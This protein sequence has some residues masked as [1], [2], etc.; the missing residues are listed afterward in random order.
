MFA[1]AAGALACG[2]GGPTGTPPA[3]TVVASVAVTSPATSVAVGATVQLAATAR[4]AAGAAIS[5]KTFTWTTSDAAV[6]TI[7]GTGVLSGVAL[8]QVVVTVSESGSGKSATVTM[9]VTPP[10]VASV[11][12]TPATATVG[13]GQ[14]QQL[15]ATLKDARGE[16]LSGRTIT[17]SS[18]NAA[19]A[20]VSGDG[21]VTGVAAGG[22]V[23]ITA[24]SEGKSAS[25]QITVP[26]VP[27]ASVTID[28]HAATVLQG[29]TL[30]LAAT[31]RDAGGA[32]LTGRTVAWTTSDPA[33]ATISSSGLLSAVAVGGPVTIT[34]TAEGK[35]ATSQ[36][37]VMPRVAAT[38]AITPAFATILS[39]A[40]SAFR[41]DASDAE[42]V[43]IPSPA[44]TWASTA[45]AVTVDAAGVVHGA[46]PGVGSIVATV[47]DAADT[48]VVAVLGASTILSTAFPSDA[49][50]A[51]AASGQT[52]V[53]HVVLDL[54]RVSPTGDL[55]AA[56]FDLRY[57]PTKLTYVSAE[58]GVTGSSNF[59]LAAP[60][61]FKFSFAH[62]AAQGQGRVTL[63]KVTFTPPAGAPVGSVATFDVVYAG[64]PANTDFQSYEMPL[65]VSG[66]VRIAAP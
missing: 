45:A 52:V 2:G 18:A 17:W 4:N 40:D 25:A 47:D 53:V 41:A 14:T 22:P 23:A 30:Q 6:A 38:V 32:T 58:A 62:T 24:T 26:A 3:D 49:F 51:A 48:A 36:V 34:A 15:T 10:P 64:A 11:A 65:V 60:G 27:V 1:A 13:I 50:E 46:T 56:Q 21:V 54:S 5:G 12:V 59:N 63:A 35:S 9:S 61:T 16:T 33:I 31:L 39:G 19:V 44:T 42:G 8:G 66:R 55:G 20:T 57:D 43:A 28:S 29:S 37:T 7:S